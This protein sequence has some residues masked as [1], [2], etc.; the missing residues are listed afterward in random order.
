M[1]SDTILRWKIK[2]Q[3]DS[4]ILQEDLNPLECWEKNWQ[5]SFN[6][7]KC[8]VLTVSRKRKQI[9]TKYSLNGQVLR[10][11]EKA[12]YLGMESTKDLNWKPHIHTITAKV[13]RTNV[14]TQ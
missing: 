6:I 11:V 14:F 12:K 3:R 4:S 13:N 7:N 1:W 2:S 5:M 10:R 8:H 9:S